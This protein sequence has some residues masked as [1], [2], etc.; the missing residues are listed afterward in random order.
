M[1]RLTHS[2]QVLL[3]VCLLLTLLC[4]TAQA[5]AQ[6]PAADLP[7]EP[8]SGFCG[9][10]G[11]G[12]NLTWTLTPE[13]VL[14]ISGK[15]AMSRSNPAPW[16]K[17]RTVMKTLVLSEGITSIGDYAFAECSGFTGPLPLPSTLT[18]I[19]NGA[20]YL[21]SGFTG[22][23]NIP[24]SVTSIGSSAFALCSGL[25]GELKLPS[26]ITVI[27]RGCFSGCS[28]FT[29]TL[30]FPQGITAIEYGAFS[31]C[32]GFTGPLTIPD[33]VTAIGAHAFSE[34]L[35]FDGPLTLPKGLTK[36]E[37]GTFGGCCALSG[38]LDL[39]SGITSIGEQAF[40]RC[41][42]LIGT[43]TLPHGLTSLGRDAFQHCSGLTG[44]LV[45]P[46]GITTI[47]SGVF[48]SCSK[49]TAV[50]IGPNTT[51]IARS[52]F[53]A[54]SG[55]TT[56]IVD[57][58]NP[59]YSSDSHGVLF[60]KDQT[61][62]IQYPLNGPVSYTIPQ[63]V[64][65][66]GPSAFARSANLA[67]VVF[68]DSVAIIEQNAF[69]QTWL[70]GSLILPASLTTIHDHAFAYCPSLTDLYF[71][72]AAPKLPYT[73]PTDRHHFPAQCTLHYLVGTTGWTDHLQYKDETQ[74]WWGYPLLPWDGS[75]TS[76]FSL[77]TLILTD[78]SGRLLTAIPNGVF[79]VETAI[80]ASAEDDLTGCLFAL[81]TPEGQLLRMAAPEPQRCADGTAVFTLRLD[82]TQGQIGTLKFFQ[83]NSLLDPAPMS[84]ALSI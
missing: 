47:Q 38:T 21:C 67:H 79:T 33:S 72:S 28:G 13:G 31:G 2:L 41:Y 35:R 59:N 19:H 76:V 14:T 32:S 74:T 84:E 36:I 52:A 68:G 56:F 43:L 51:S 20:F 1:K 17:Y 24:Q 82:N 71:Q 5:T 83:L 18:T 9:G 49:L 8:I 26:S 25:S 29:G 27:Q 70:S 16:Y 46:D 39:P 54:N 57:P 64:T 60:N 22:T 69:A 65:T 78:D 66:I 42:S 75:Y 63:S 12:S 81:Y 61:I 53:Y 23:L 58:E 77:N 37:A 7:A 40:F 15:G 73:D 10:E 6:S 80:A 62:L 48:S 11:D 55:L 34:C 30:V 50:A 45:I 4:I 3:T 44:T